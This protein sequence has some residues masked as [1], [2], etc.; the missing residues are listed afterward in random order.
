MQALALLHE[1]EE[2]L[3]PLPFVM[4]VAAYFLMKWAA[5]GKPKDA[6]DAQQEPTAAAPRGPEYKTPTFD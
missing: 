1:G 5:S 3:I 6:D 2:L 4:M